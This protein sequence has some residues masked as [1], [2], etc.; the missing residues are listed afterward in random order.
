M[1]DQLEWWCQTESSPKGYRILIF[2]FNTEPKITISTFMSICPCFLHTSVFKDE[3]ISRHIF[4]IV[5][6]PTL[7]KKIFETS[8]IKIK[9]SF[10]VIFFSCPISDMIMKIDLLKNFQLIEFLLW[11]ARKCPLPCSSNYSF[12]LLGWN[13]KII[14]C[15]QF[16]KTSVDFWS[17]PVVSRG[18]YY[19][20]RWQHLIRIYFE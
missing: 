13:S 1:V 16:C 18:W 19:V 10:Q 9:F 8:K 15:G 12:N 2:F 5:I 17:T 6:I 7:W 11:L 20:S 4:N 14:R 3:N